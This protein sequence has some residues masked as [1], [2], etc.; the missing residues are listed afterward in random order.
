MLYKWIANHFPSL[1]KYK[2][3]I[4]ATMHHWLGVKRTYSQHEEDVFILATLK[5][6]NL[7]DSIYVD[8]GANHPTD[9]SN[10]Y[11]LYRNGMRGVVIEPNP[12]LI[13][14]F[15]KFR[16]RDIALMIGCSN[17]PALLKFNISKTPV[18]SSFL[19][20]RDAD[21]YKSVYIPVLPVDTALH[22]IDFEY[23]NFLSI[24]V[25]GLNVQVL[26]GAI[27]I[28]KKTLLIC[29]EYD[30]DQEKERFFEILKND[31]VQINELGCNV[32]YLNKNLSKEYLILPEN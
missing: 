14:L 7:T 32:I 6:Y 10:S 2:R 4:V 15:A 1:G 3:Y 19:T 29:L 25:E 13:A 22:N 30:N 18:V 8:I 28:I 24:D 11:L 27:E 9:I 20:E 12:E 26:Q 31:F 21:F 17:E 5:K 23:I 16:K